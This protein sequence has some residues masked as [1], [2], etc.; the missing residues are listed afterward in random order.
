[1]PDNEDDQS[2]MR[3]LAERLT[4]IRREAGEA[5]LRIE[6]L[7]AH[8]EPGPNR[9]EALTIAYKLREAIK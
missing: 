7:G 8:F 4:R 2:G 1:M 9:T 3:L 6:F 5:A